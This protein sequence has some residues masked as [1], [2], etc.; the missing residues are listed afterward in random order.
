MSNRKLVVSTGNQHKIEEIKEILKGLPIEVVSKKDLGF[1]SLNIL[2]D[3]E[4]L[5][6]NSLKK[7]KGLADKLDNMVLADDSGLFVDI[8]DGNPGVYSS[9]Y[10]GEEGNDEKNNRKLL[11]ELQD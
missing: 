5:E 4:T 9:R 7:A 3:G 8:L 2:E 10:A 6:D 11:Q 1:G